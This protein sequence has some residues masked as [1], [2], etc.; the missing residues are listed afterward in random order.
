MDDAIDKVDIIGNI[1]A[2]KI[3]WM[4]L[5]VAAEKTEA[6]RFRRIGERRKKG[7]ATITIENTRIKLGNTI[8]Y[9]GITVRDDWSIKDHL[10]RTVNK[11]ESVVNKLSKLMLNKKGPSEKKRRLYQNITNSVLL[12][13]AP[14]WVINKFSRLT[15]K[16]RALQRKVAIRVIRAYRTVSEEMA[17]MLAR[18][19]PAELQA[20]KLKAVYDRKRAAGDENIRISDR[21]LSIIRKQENDR[22]INKWRLKLVEKAD[23]GRGFSLEVLSCFKEWVG[24]NHGELTFQATQLITGHSCFRGYT[25]RI[26]KTENSQCSFCGRIVE[27][28]VHVLIECHEWR[29][30]RAGKGVWREGRIVGGAVTRKWKAMLEFAKK[31]MH[32]KEEVEREKQAEARQKRLIRE[33]EEILGER[34]GGARRRSPSPVQSSQT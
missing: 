11:A 29:E 22:M 13:G 16:V 19:P 3:K 15:K 2:R 28:N 26:G 17:P 33:T 24:R 25:H 18:N 23:T 9:L 32:T 27:D 31:V 20:G 12:Y 14:V 1:I 10:E 4:C 21:G 34:S 7:N 6:I 8:N 5:Q 30:E